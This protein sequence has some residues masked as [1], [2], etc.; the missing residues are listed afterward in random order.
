[1]PSAVA[2]A[3]SKLSNS[4]ERTFE[5][6]IW[7][8]VADSYL[9]GALGQADLAGDLVEIVSLSLGISEQLTPTAAD[10]AAQARDA[11]EAATVATSLQEVVEVLTNT[12]VELDKLL[13]KLGEWDNFHSILTLTRDLLNRQQN[14]RQ[15]TENFAEDN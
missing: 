3:R 4:F 10:A 7:T 8:E 12:Q 14:L 15:R 1:M 6:Q 5:P 13:A 2:A 9:A 11:S